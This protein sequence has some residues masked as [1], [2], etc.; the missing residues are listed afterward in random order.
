M[1]APNKNYLFSGSRDKTIRV[2]NL[3]KEGKCEI[4]LKK[5]INTVACLAIN[6]HGGY[7]LSGSADKTI[8]IWKI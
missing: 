7:L 3:Y 2:W 4:L 5:H 8:C 1:M 6:K